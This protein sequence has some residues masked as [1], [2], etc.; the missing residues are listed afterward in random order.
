MRSDARAAVSGRPAPRL[1]IT[2][3]QTPGEV[4]LD[5]ADAGPRLAPQTR[6]RGFDP[7]FTI[8]AEAAGMGLTPRGPS[9]AAFQ[10]RRPRRPLRCGLHSPS[11][12]GAKV[13]T[14]G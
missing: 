13:A 11:D 10:G 1:R 12:I 6:S 8:N 7:V 14:S 2:G 5:L 4:R 3:G 9:P